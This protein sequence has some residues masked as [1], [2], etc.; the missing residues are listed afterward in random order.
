MP[1]WRPP[2][3]VAYR[4][5]C[6]YACVTRHMSRDTHCVTRVALSR[7]APR[8]ATSDRDEPS[9]GLHRA[10]LAGS[11]WNFIIA[12]LYKLMLPSSLL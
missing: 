11:L 10:Y 8:R 9:L 4:R 7:R 2:I 5:T 12:G 3:E 1:S 6:V